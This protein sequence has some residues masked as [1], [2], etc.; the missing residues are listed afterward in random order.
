MANSKIRPSLV[1]EAQE[2]GMAGSLST[3]GNQGWQN[4]AEIGGMELDEDEDLCCTGCFP[5][6]W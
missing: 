3:L 1:T 6:K 4:G 5:G 2:L